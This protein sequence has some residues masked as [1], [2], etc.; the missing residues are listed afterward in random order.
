MSYKSQA[1]ANYFLDLAA[2]AN[3][4]LTQMKLQKLVYFAHGWN[5]GLTGKPLINEHIQAWSYGP[6][7]R[8]L[9]NCFREF[10]SGPLLDGAT[11]VVQTGSNPFQFETTKPSILDERTERPELTRV[12]LDK[13][14]SVY[15]GYSAI[16]LSNLTHAPGTPW[17]TI[18]K[19][20]NGSIPKYATI[21]NELIADY[22]RKE[23]ARNE[24]SSTA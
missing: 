19:I 13:I 17:D 8:S 24:R 7:V 22:F 16:Q 4:F 10:G 12:L 3:Q 5:L 15:G 21:P 6:V 20:Y 18:N 14:W 2:S 23:A 1:I 9:Y 11:E